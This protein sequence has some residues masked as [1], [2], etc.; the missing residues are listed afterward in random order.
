M[1]AS[2]QLWRAASLSVAFGS[3]IM[4]LVGA[5]LA[6]MLSVSEY[7]LVSNTSGLALAIAGIFKVI[8]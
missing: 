3:I 5:F 6:F 4:M 2:P 1:S 8:Y 7:M